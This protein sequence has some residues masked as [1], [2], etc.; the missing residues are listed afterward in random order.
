MRGMSDDRLAMVGEALRAA[1]PDLRLSLAV[2]GDG[3]ARQVT[4]PPTV[5]PDARFLVYSVTKTLLAALVLRLVDAGRVD[6][7]AAVE[8]PALP[9]RVTLRQLLRHTAG[10]ADYGGLPA[11]H[12]AVRSTPGE[13]WRFDALLSETLAH[14]AF[15]PD[16]GWGYS[17]LG[18]RLV[19]RVVEHAHGLPLTTIVATELARPL[20]LLH[21]GL[22]DA[23][24]DLAAL[25]PGSTRC[26]GEGALVDVRGRYHPGWVAHG[27]VAATAPE[28]ARLVHAILCGD[29]LS[30]AS[31]AA[32]ATLVPVP[33]VH[34]RFV[35][36]AYGL[37]V[38]GDPGAARGPTFGHTGGG[39][40]YAA[41]VYHAGG[42][43]VAVLANA[44]VSAEVEALALAILDGLQLNSA[45]DG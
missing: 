14:P 26:L 44:E 33:V 6:L 23:P 41:A 2:V 17:N 29:V 35:T 7:D 12:E 25:E 19:R 38:M 27:V 36:P 42:V 31:R 22:A 21:T 3:D 13:P 20:G 5:A 1:W 11:Y 4:W 34:P 24:S 10:L 39:P 18:Y 15:A 32:M 45:T 40:G 8:L 16:T 43:T 9:T 28:I 37:G 30:E